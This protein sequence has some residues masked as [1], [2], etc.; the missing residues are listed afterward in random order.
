LDIS[1][2]EIGATVD[3]LHPH[4]F[5]LN[6]ILHEVL[7]SP[8]PGQ[9]ENMLIFLSEWREFSSAFGLAGQKK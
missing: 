3:I 4:V 8:L 1:N 2:P 6:H 5:F 7:I 9:E